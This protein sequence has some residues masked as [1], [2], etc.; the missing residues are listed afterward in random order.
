[1]GGLFVGRDIALTVPIDYNKYDLPILN[2]EVLRQHIITL[3]G[4]VG[5]R[6]R[7]GANARREWAEHYTAERMAR[8]TFEVYKELAA[9][10]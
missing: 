10:F 7:L 5:L 3:A 2:E 4:D 6:K 9:Q 1:M 8:E